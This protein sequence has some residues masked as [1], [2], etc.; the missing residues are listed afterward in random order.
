MQRPGVTPKNEEQ[1]LS[2]GP[3]G[4]L[5]WSAG[6]ALATALGAGSASAGSI[7]IPN[8]YH[9]QQTSFFCGEGAMEMQLDSPQVRSTNPTV[10]NALNSASTSGYGFVNENGL[11]T[12][13]QLGDATIQGQLYGVT[14]SI[15]SST[16]W[17]GFANAAFASHTGTPPGAMARVMNAADAPPLGNDNYAA[18]T[19]APSAVGANAAS[20]TLALSMALFNVPGSAVVMHGA[21][22]ID[23]HGVRTTGNIG[24]GQPYLI[25]GFFVRDPWTGFAFTNPSQSSGIFGLGFN[26]YLRYGSPWFSFFNPAF[27]TSNRYVLEL[28]P[29][30][31]VPV[32]DGTNDSLPPPPPLLGSPLDAT[33]A[34]SQAAL[35]L[36]ADPVLDTEPG[37]VGGGFDS[38]LSD[39]MQVTIGGDTDWVVPYDGSGGSNDVTGALL[40]DANTGVID[41]AT[42]IDPTEDPVSSMMLSQLDAMYLD[43]Q[44]G[45]LPQDD[46]IAGDVPEPATVLLLSPALAFLAVFR[47]RIAGVARGVLR[48]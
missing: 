22:W 4:A 23:V 19:F 30:G 47:R 41:Q 34:L 9:Y 42:W 38:L 14:P 26:T 28:E 37:L 40:I 24:L 8:G 18:Y 3:R 45:L 13:V 16:V 11:P 36:A 1:A 12:L 31:P 35:D 39:L 29:Q 43:E 27:N 25:N 5:A 21:H 7:V 48:G 20:R 6:F 10:N 17:D 33:G 2:E 46:P 32:D 44:N 15:L